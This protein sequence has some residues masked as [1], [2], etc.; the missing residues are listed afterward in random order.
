MFITAYLLKKEY[1]PAYL[2]MP[3][4]W[5]VREIHFN[6]MARLFLLIF[7][8]N[9]VKMLYFRWKFRL[10]NCIIQ[11]ER[12][13]V[14][15]SQSWW[16]TLILCLVTKYIQVINFNLHVI[17][18]KHS[19]FHGEIWLNSWQVTFYLFKLLLAWKWPNF[20][21]LSNTKLMTK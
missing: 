14:C 19:V 5:K 4:V 9:C 16:V 20:K 13:M 18:S 2:V 8:M 3:P 15:S 6:P 7:I 1:L 10:L 21:P 11:W 12:S 17:W